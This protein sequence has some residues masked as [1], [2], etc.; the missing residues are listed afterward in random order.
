MT[1]LT[2]ALL[3][4]AAEPLTREKIEAHYTQVRDALTAKDF[5]KFIGLVEPAKERP[6]PPKDVFADAAPT[7]LEMAYPE[8]SKT[9]F[10][11]TESKKD[12]AGY[13][14]ITDPDDANYLT[15]TFL[16]LHGGPKGWKLL[17]TMFSSSVRR[18]KDAAEDEAIIKKEIAKNPQLRL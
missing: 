5:D 15:I 4:L 17:G 6:L 8:L 7:I 9:K 2:L 13:W 18:G 11:K 1:T 14:M 16:K 12:F 10:I 3:V